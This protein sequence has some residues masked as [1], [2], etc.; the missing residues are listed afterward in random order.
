MLEN[1]LSLE[2]EK[3]PILQNAE[4]QTEPIGLKRYHNEAEKE[5]DTSDDFTSVRNLLSIM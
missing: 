4:C 2:M 1:K 5:G 3:G